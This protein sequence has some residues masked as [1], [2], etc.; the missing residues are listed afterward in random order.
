M[1]GITEVFVATHDAAVQRAAALDKALEAIGEGGAQV[2]IPDAPHTRINGITDWEI[3]RLGQLAGQAVH[4]VGEDE[5]A[6]A[7]VASETLYVAPESMVRAFADLLAETSDD[8]APVLPDVAAAWASEEDMP[9]SG[10]AAVESV[11]RIGEL[12]ADAAEDGRQQLY[13]WSGTE[14]V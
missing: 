12:A 14:S 8:G 13:V 9:L 1:S 10:D 2:E 7:D 6:I 11:K 3:E 4:S 5:L